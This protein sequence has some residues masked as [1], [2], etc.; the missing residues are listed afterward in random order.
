M[1]AADDARAALTEEDVQAIVKD[2]LRFWLGNPFMTPDMLAEKVVW[3]I[4]AVVAARVAAAQAEALEQ[5]ADEVDYS[6]YYDPAASGG[7]STSC[8][9]AENAGRDWLRERARGLRGEP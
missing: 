3:W 2:D 7:V 5:A 4:N 6:G 1:T 8:H 9:L